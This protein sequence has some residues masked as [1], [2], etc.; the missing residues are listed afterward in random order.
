MKWLLFLNIFFI[1]S[2]LKI[3]I[4]GGGILLSLRSFLPHR[5]VVPTP[6]ARCRQKQFSWRLITPSR[7]QGAHSSKCPPPSRHF[8]PRG[9]RA[10]EAAA[11]ME[12]REPLTRALSLLVNLGQV[13]LEK[14]QQEAAGMKIL[15][16]SN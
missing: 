12:E 9:T 3:C 8:T 10:K 16:T 7:D 15:Q 5:A 4:L 6:V 2:L 13:L 1:Y 11:E 14:A